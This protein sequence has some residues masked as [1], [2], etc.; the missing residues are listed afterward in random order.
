MKGSRQINVQGVSKYLG[1]HNTQEA[2]EAART[3]ANKHYGFHANHGST[4]YQ[5]NRK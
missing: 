2:A 4:N 3:V 1:T 5:I